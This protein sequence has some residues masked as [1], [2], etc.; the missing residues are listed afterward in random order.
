MKQKQKDKLADNLPACAVEF[1]RLVIKK[2]RYRK[3]VWQD[4]QVELAAHFEDELKEC[5][6]DEEKAQKAQQLIAGFGDVKLLAV[7]LRRAKKRCRPLWR[8]AVART[9]QTIGVLIVCFVIY[10]VWFLTGK[11]SITVDYLA[12]LNQMDQAQVRVEDNA[13]PHYEKAITL[14]VEP[15]QSIKEVIAFS[16]WWSLNYRSFAELSEEKKREIRKWV[17][18]NEAAWREFIAGSEKGYC[19]CEWERKDQNQFL[20]EIIFSSHD[21]LRSLAKLGIWRTR[22]AVANCEISK[23]LMECV[24]ITRVGKH[25]QSRKGLIAE[26]RIGLFLSVQAWDEILFIVATRDVSASDLTKT[27]EQLE[28]IYGAGFPLLDIKQER[29]Y[30]LGVVQQFF[31]QGGPGGGHIL[32]EKA[33]VLNIEDVADSMTEKAQAIVGGHW[34]A[35]ALFTAFCLRHAGRDETVAKYDEIYH[36]MGGIVKMT[37][38]ERHVKGI[39]ADDEEIRQQLYKQKRFFLLVEAIPPFLYTSDWIYCGKS[40][41]GA[42]LTILALQRWRLERSEYP[43]TLDELIESGYLKE[44]PTDPYS[45][46]PLVYKKTDDDFALYSVGKNFRDDAGKVVRY[47]RTGEIAK[48]GFSGSGD[49]VFWPVPKSQLKQ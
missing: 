41:Y 4:V 38:Y 24:T 44:L 30:F 18:H 36:E 43:A 22:I 14:F 19:Y 28:D 23:A 45:D 31:T 12:I 6:T 34:P 48:W 7:L 10:V 42:L 21:G 33:R 40:Q 8:T 47:Y 35:A 3:K 39:E 32:P 17:E 29:S 9:F 16:G 46:K 2:M 27:Q 26:Q 20:W 49:T 25:W 5:A 13:W 15:S 11:P 1:I 37:P